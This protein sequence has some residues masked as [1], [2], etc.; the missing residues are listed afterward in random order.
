MTIINGV[1]YTPGNYTHGRILGCG[2]CRFDIEYINDSVYAGQKITTFDL[3]VGSEIPDELKGDFPDTA[4]FLN[5]AAKINNA[6]QQSVYNT[7]Q[8]KLPKDLTKN[9]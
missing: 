2:G 1:T 5:G 3:W 7:E 4:K 9:A 8:Y 6:F